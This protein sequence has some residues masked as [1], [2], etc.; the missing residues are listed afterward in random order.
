MSR[1][2]RKKRH[3]RQWKCKQCTQKQFS[4]CGYCL[5]HL[6]QSLRCIRV[7]TKGKRCKLPIVTG[8]DICK[9]HIS[10]T[11]NGSGSGKYGWVYVFDTGHD[12]GDKKLYKV[13]RSTSP[14]KRGQALRAGNPRGNM[15]FA[16]FVG[17]KAKKIEGKLH[18]AMI[19]AGR[20]VER[21]IFSLSERDLI[22]L[23]GTLK[24]DSLEWQDF[25]WK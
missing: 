3:K 12:D 20:W 6:P 9:V 18:R 1:S 10:N 14:R 16:G 24:S 25:K 17:D 8:T 21:E 11:M 5:A 4:K 22:R 2:Q 19:T 13:G 23:R 7:T 15:M